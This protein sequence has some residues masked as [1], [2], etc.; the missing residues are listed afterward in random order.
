MLLQHIRIERL[1]NLDLVSLDDL[2]PFNIFVGA[3]G[4]GKTSILEAI[5][6]LATGRSFRT[7]TPKHYIQHQQKDTLIFAQSHDIRIGMQKFASGEQIMRVNSENI[8]TQGQLAKL[9]PVQVL[10]PQSTAIIDEGA[11]PRRQMLD[12]LMFHVEPRFFEHWQYY[13]R[14]L[15]QRNQLLKSGGVNAAQLAVW[16][17]MLAESGE[18]IHQMRMQ[19]VKD[20]QADIAQELQILLPELV[21]ELDYY[22]GFNVDT[23]LLAQL[24]HD[25]ERDLE[26]RTTQHGV[27]RADLRIKTQH[28]FADDILSR[29]Q[30]KLLIIALKLAQIA[31]LNRLN[32]ETVVLLDDVT[33]ELDSAAQE[34][35]ISRLYQLESQVFLTTLAQS[36][37]ESVLD[38][39]AAPYCIYQVQ[40]GQVQRMDA[41]QTDSEQANGFL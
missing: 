13:T 26:R 1:R 8:A 37:V 32:K 33:A 10:E 14:A 4:S 29:G 11:Q 22:A 41:A 3:N 40:D 7:Y 18:Q 39:N 31:M 21:I 28:G 23:G 15:K 38:H 12:W 9:L 34:R 30:K 17:E 5:H 24:Q 36:A 27:H 20:W 35:L 2:Q 16:D 25:Y 19:V 6:L